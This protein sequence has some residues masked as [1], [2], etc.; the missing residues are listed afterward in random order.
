[1][2][3]RAPRT[4]A[5]PGSAE[6]AVQSGSRPA[7][8][9]SSRIFSVGYRDRQFRTGKIEF[10]DYDYLK[11]PKKLLA[12]KEAAEKYTHSKLEVYDYPGKYDEKDKGEQFAKFRLEAEQ[13]FDHRRQADGDAPSMFAGGL[14]TVEKHPTS[15][16]NKEYLVVRASHSVRHAALSARSQTPAPWSLFR[17]SMNSS[18]ATGHSAACR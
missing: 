8:I 11:P 2:P 6:A 3:I 15:A 18:R 12:H 13:S 5:I 4:E 9:G 7:T 1:M 17:A 16:E 10:N 14:V